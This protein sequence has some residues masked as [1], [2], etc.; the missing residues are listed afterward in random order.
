V[1]GV[2]LAD[3]TPAL[4]LTETATVG[5]L[6][7]E[8]VERRL[9]A[10][11]IGGAP[12]FARLLD[13]VL[14]MPASELSAE[15]RRAED[16]AR[17]EKV[18]A[19]ETLYASRISVL[20][21]SAGTGKTTLLRVLRHAPSV[22]AGGVLLVA[23]TG[24]A[25]VQLE[26]RVRAQAVTLAQFLIRTGRYDPETERYRVTGDAQSRAKDY[27]TV[28]VDEASMLTEEQLA[29]LLDAVTGVERLVLVGDPRQLPPIGAGRPFVDLIRRLAPE[30]IATRTPRCAPGYAE[31]TI[32][33][34][35]TG[36]ERDDLVLASWFA[37]GELSPA[38]DL[39]WER[40]RTGVA[41]ETLRAVPYR[42]AELFETLLGVLRE[43]IPELRKA[44]DE[45]L[46]TA[47][48]E[49]Y[50]GQVSTKGN[51]YFPARTAPKH[52]D[53]W[54]I[55]SPVRGRAWGTVEIN[56]A[57]KDAYCG[58]ALDQ[59][60]GPRRY[61]AKPIGPERIVVGDKVINLRNH[62]FKEKQVYPKD[63]ELFVANG[64]IGVVV[65]QS[66]SGA[67]T[68]TP[69]KTEIAFSGRPGVKY[70]YHDWSDDDRAPM[71]ELAWAITIHKAQGSEFGITLVVLPA[72][73]AGLS[74]ELL[75]TAHLPASSRKWCYCTRHPW[76]RSRD[77]GP[78][79]TPTPLGG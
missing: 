14:G 23:P 29:A 41:M 50:G 47:F 28:V 12:D 31:L 72:G 69:N 24:K 43:E 38:A 63:A 27:R 25:R 1:T 42:R 74:R 4:Q 36:P 64:E 75:Y 73:G 57:L 71:L 77:S 34:R 13:A 22:A 10:A 21:G 17:R 52:A 70:D 19:L 54:Q 33:R 45:E 39:V 35:Q 62:M 44:S 79:S 48:G 16:L 8:Q 58:R 78:R 66:R 2:T 53:D 40:L 49:S 51:L 18:A 56:R 59:A 5:R 9:R 15:E 55:L 67:V 76:T 60:T 7:R 3:G 61:H 32:P 46:A 37:D 20:V 26:H 6:I 65:G 68:W 11:P 30:D